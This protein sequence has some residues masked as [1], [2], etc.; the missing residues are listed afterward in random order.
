LKTY[1]QGLNLSGA[2]TDESEQENFIS[3]SKT[4]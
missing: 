3:Y 1:R 4:E 2:S